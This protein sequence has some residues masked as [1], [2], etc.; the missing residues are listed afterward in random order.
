MSDHTLTNLLSEMA[1]LALRNGRL[2]P[3]IYTDISSAHVF[4]KALAR[5]IGP[6]VY[7]LVK[8]DQGCIVMFDGVKI[9]TAPAPGDK[10]WRDHFGEL[11][12]IWT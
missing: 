11:A 5:E 4:R 7:S 9:C 8:L 6:L 2:A 12:E 10:E 3:V 1:D